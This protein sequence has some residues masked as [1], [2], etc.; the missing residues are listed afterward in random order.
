MP[1]RIVDM[2]VDAR[3]SSQKRTHLGPFNTFLPIILGQMTTDRFIKKSKD[4]SE[5][6]F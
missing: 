4:T 5:D 1:R 6:L 2:N 3:L